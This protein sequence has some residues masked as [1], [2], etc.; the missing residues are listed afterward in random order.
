VVPWVV[1]VDH[2]GE[3]RAIAPATADYTPSDQ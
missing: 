2:L 1:R 3:A